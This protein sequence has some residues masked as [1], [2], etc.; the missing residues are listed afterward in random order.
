MYG[1]GWE[2]LK[3]V[4]IVLRFEEFT[5]Q[6]INLFLNSGCIMKEQDLKIMNSENM[7]TWGQDIICHCW[8]EKL[9]GTLKDRCHTQV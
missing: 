5:N 9:E 1:N 8:L 7:Q 6:N 4:D 3:R 2:E